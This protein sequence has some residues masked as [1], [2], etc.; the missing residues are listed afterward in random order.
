MKDDDSVISVA[1]SNKSCD[2]FGVDVNVNIWSSSMCSC[3]SWTRTPQEV[4]EA[5]EHKPEYWEQYMGLGVS[6]P[7]IS[8]EPA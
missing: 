3:G 6:F 2:G 4:A 7:G 8:E 5:M 1:C